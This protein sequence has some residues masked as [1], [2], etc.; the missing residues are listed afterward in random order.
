MKNGVKIKTIEAGE[1][2]GYLKGTRDYYRKKK[3]VIPNS[4]LLNFLKENGLQI[5]RQATR[6]I[7]NVSF[8][9]GALDADDEIKKLKKLIKNN[10]DKKNV[11][12]LII[13]E[14]EEEKDKYK[15]ESIQEIREEFYKNGFTLEYIDKNNNIEC[16]HYQ[17][18]FRSPA[19]ARVG[20]C[21]FINEKLYDKV[22]KWQRMGLELPE[23][24]AKIV[25]M[26]AYESLTS[27]S[28][29]NTIKINVDDIL[30]VKDVES[31]FMT[32]A[33]IVY[34][35]KNT[36][37]VKEEITELKNTLWD[38]MALIEAS[39]L[40]N[41]G[42]GMAL[43]RQHF[44][45]ACAFKA[46]IQL[47]FKEYYGDEYE[48]ATITD[49]F[50][51][52]H[53]VKDIKMITTDNAIKWLKFKDLMGA[54]DKDA[55]QYWKSKVKEDNNIFGICK[56]DHKS[57]LKNKQQLSYQMINTLPINEEE[58]KEIAEFSYN[59]L[60]ELKNNND[61]FIEFLKD[62]ADMVNVN[63]M[64]I[65]LFNCNPSIA[66]TKEW[67]TMK[68]NILKNYK[69]KLKKGKIQVEGDNLT[70]CGNPMAL[71]KYAVGDKDY[72]IDNTLPVEED[73]ITCYTTRFADNEFLAG[74][75][76][77]HNSPNNIVYL[78][79]HYSSEMNRYFPF[80]DNIIAINCI[81]TDVQDRL[82]GADFD[83]DFALVTNNKIIVKAA[84]ECYQ[85]FPTIYNAIPKSNKSYNNT[86]SDYADM[87]NS[88]AEARIAIGVSSNLAQLAM[89][90]YW[91]EKNEIFKKQQKNNFII[92][93]VLAQVAIDNAKR[94][95]NVN[96][97]K[98]IKTISKQACMMNNKPNFWRYI[99]ITDPKKINKDI[100][101][102]MNFLTTII[103][104][105]TISAPK[106][107]T[108][109]FIDYV[110]IQEEKPNKKQIKK[111]IDIVTEY[112][113]SVKSL[114][115]SDNNNPENLLSQLNLLHEE[116]ILKLQR[117]SLSEAT[118]NTLI[119]KALS[120]RK[121]NK[122][123]S[124]VRFKL[125]NCLYNINSKRFINNFI[126]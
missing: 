75:R 76:N 42:N 73:T 71:L 81:S 25:E 9:F 49:M 122:K 72:L 45:K 98:E 60:N 121:N 54:T 18:W 93:S 30:I 19:K 120:D 113:T 91:G 95:Y 15:A 70:L 33:N 108:T 20:D 110:K 3:A 114:M 59:Y 69:I 38:G 99:N 39:F 43:L 1:L 80:S 14:I 116:I 11:Y 36:C 105:N 5:N 78:H 103:D 106:T 117:L 34:T 115:I 10:P 46:N 35:D 77:P 125:L 65:D 112:D 102:P 57:K 74:F 47:F 123:Y 50:G 61:K 17:M 55:Y 7:I 24:Q 51:T 13:D 48:T 126:K 119:I 92:L 37:K 2:F 8:S 100:K 62:T 88:L 68:N 82:N 58:V 94:V 53:F 109:N 67:R 26:S 31:V 84:K 66:N 96:L 63:D 101:C 124:S 32:N 29:I 89:S 44:F 41:K 28:I 104:K 21:L 118:I 90:Y 107:N 85:N 6:D 12:E 22:I 52:P 23:K 97:N 40:G 16:I 111:I 64:M 83:S 87:D 86:L 56:T 79:N 4:L 27:S